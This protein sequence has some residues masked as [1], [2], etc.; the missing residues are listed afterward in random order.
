MHRLRVGA[1]FGASAD[2]TIGSGFVILPSPSISSDSE[3]GLGD[4]CMDLGGRAKRQGG[5]CWVGPLSG[6]WLV[7]AVGWTRSSGKW[8]HPKWRGTGGHE[9]CLGGVWP[10][11]A[12]EKPMPEYCSLGAG[13]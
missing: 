3:S 2:P 5:W 12:L 1:Q 4:V 7:K 9:V 11:G 6:S 13:P 10:T 8:F